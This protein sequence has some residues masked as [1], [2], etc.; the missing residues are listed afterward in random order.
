ML[1]RSKGGFS[2]LIKVS[3][4]EPE[5]NTY[6]VPQ[7][8]SIPIGKQVRCTV[9]RGDNLPTETRWI[10]PNLQQR[11]SPHGYLATCEIFILGMQLSAHYSSDS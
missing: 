6:I 2:D 9:S 3:R 1:I 8:I 5:R 7:G 11:E 10:D 4:N